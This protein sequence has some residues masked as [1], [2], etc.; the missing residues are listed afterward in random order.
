MELNGDNTA[1]FN[2]IT[3]NL[4][5]RYS[6]G[7]GYRLTNATIIKGEYSFNLEKKGTGGEDPVDNLLSILVSS[8]F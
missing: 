8:Q 4:Y 3:T 6:L 1:S 2:S 5:E 7:L